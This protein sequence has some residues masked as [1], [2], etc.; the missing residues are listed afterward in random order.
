M[1]NAPIATS[2]QHLLFL[3]LLVVAPAWDFYDT[4]RLKQ[5]SDSSVKI[6]YYKTLCVWLWLA[7]GVA[8]LAVGFRP[9][10]F[11]DPARGEASWLFD[12]AWVRY[13]LETVL[14][15]F[16]AVTLLP[17]AIVIRK[18]LRKQ[19]RTYSSADAWKSLAYFFPA[20]WVERRWFA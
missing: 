15:L 11:I 4:G 20:T 16:V 10:F 13:L 9:L 1:F 8:Y 2:V 14:A 12:H 3:F 18:K 6:R 5:S 7:A 17:A 19:P